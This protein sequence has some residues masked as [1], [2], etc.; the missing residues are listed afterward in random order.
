MFGACRKVEFG[1]GDVMVLTTDGFF[2]WANAAGEQFGT[3][4]L[5]EFVQNNDDL[6]PSELITRLHEAV[7]AHAAGTSQAD[8]LTALVI[9]KL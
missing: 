6:S 8:D 1:H 2:E 7:L 4:R 9:K 3:K 5:V